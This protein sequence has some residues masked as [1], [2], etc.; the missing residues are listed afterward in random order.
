MKMYKWHFDGFDIKFIS[1]EES[2]DRHITSQR[3]TLQ[4]QNNVIIDHEYDDTNPVTDSPCRTCGTKSK[5]KQLLSSSSGSSETPAQET[6][7]LFTVPGDVDE[8]NP[9]SLFLG[10]DPDLS[11]LGGSGNGN[12]VI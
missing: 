5:K 9:S 12:P 10:D 4:T 7:G 3:E 2:L 11:L 8:L 1:S 6:N